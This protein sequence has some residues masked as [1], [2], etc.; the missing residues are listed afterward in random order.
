MKKPRILLSGKSNLQ[1]Y[2]DAVAASGGEPIAKYLPEVSTDYDGL[3]LSGGNDTDP[4]FYHQP[5][6]GAVDIDLP[7]DEAELALLHA[8]V[9]AKKPVLGICRG[10]QLINV[11]FG[12]SLVQDIPT[13]RLHAHKDD[14]YITHPV[15]AA[16]HSLLH[17][18]YGSTFTVNSCHHQV[19]DRLGTGLIATAYWNNTYIEAFQHSSLPIMGVQWHPE[20][21]CT[22][23]KRPDT[24]DGSKIFD[25]F[26]NLCKKA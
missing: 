25:W 22:S 14:L 3:I 9:A 5:F 15:T 16:D 23:Q 11:Y 20:R 10:H 18:M 26:V 2:V 4:K 8:F 13:K 7:R 6:L 17:Q 24:V 1:Y 21:M 19:V 12:G